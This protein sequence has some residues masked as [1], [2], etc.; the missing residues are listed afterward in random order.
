MA[1]TDGSTTPSCNFTVGCTLGHPPSLTIWL[2]VLMALSMKETVSGLAMGWKPATLPVSSSEHR[3]GRPNC[4]DGEQQEF[5]R[6]QS[7]A[8]T[9]CCCR[10]K[11]TV[12]T[13][14]KKARRSIADDPNFFI[15]CPTLWKFCSQPAAYGK[16]RQLRLPKLS[17]TLLT[18]SN[19]HTDRAIVM[20][21]MPTSP[22]GRLWSFTEYEYLCRISTAI[23]RINDWKTLRRCLGFGS[24]AALADKARL[25]IGAKPGF[26]YVWIHPFT[27]DRRW[28]CSRNDRDA[29]EP[30]SWTGILPP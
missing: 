30:C 10:S 24:L 25:R 1:A 19:F 6:Y 12:A 29:E 26:C 8:Q 13:P 20:V 28:S 22:H 7:A 11:P 16:K 21:Q 5:H 3:T 15:F 17:G 2:Y 4:R 18:N 14:V 9:R 27:C 23:W